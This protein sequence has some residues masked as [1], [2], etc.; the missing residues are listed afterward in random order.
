MAG[1]FEFEGGQS[2][3]IN[4]VDLHMIGACQMSNFS[5]RSLQKNPNPQKLTKCVG[6]HTLVVCSQICIS[7]WTFVC[8]LGVVLDYLTI[9]WYWALPRGAPKPPNCCSLFNRITWVGISI[10]FVH[11]ISGLVSFRVHVKLSCQISW[12]WPDLLKIVLCS[13]WHY[14]DPFIFPIHT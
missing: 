12:H 6:P 9:Q 4:C 1:Q 11:V 3:F 2:W 7:V 8:V 10:V 14:K 13:G 5:T